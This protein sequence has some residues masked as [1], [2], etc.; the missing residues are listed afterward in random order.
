MVDAHLAQSREFQGALQKTF[1]PAN[2]DPSAVAS[3]EA[4]EQQPGVTK[5]L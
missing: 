5:A 3:R 2:T 4:V 1:D